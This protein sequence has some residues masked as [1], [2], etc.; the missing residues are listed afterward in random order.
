[1]SDGQINDT[2]KAAI[3]REFTARSD[4]LGIG[5]N[6]GP[7]YT[8]QWAE[9]IYVFPDGRC[10]YCG[11]PITS[12]RI[13]KIVGRTLVARWKVN[14]QTGRLIK[15]SRPTHPHVNGSGIC[16]GSAKTAADALFTAMNPAD[17]YSSTSFPSHLWDCWDHDCGPGGRLSRQPRQRWFS[18]AEQSV[19]VDGL[20]PLG[21]EEPSDDEILAD[22]TG[23]DE[24]CSHD[25][26]QSCCD[27]NE[28]G[29]VWNY[30]DSPRD[31]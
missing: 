3:L 4:E 17:A 30:D 27:E 11:G 8:W 1:M 16:Q 6:D 21:N 25:C 19:P 10:P 12:N 24:E 20:P 13:W 18:D 2:H 15:E 5:S 31:F 9:G 23:D 28:C 14:R 22:L 29:F 7:D 26:C